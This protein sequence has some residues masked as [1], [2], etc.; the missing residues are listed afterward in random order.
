M[1]LIGSLVLVALLAAATP[2]RKM[3]PSESL[4]VLGLVTLLTI[5][6]F[7]LDKLG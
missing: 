7:Q 5:T 4:L 3:V 2:L 1:T 6:L